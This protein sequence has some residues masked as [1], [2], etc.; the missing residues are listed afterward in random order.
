MNCDLSAGWSLRF[1]RTGG[2]AGR[3]DTLTIDHAGK[4]NASSERPP[5]NTK[6]TVD[7]ETLN[8]I[9][10]AIQTDCPFE[11]SNAPQCADCYAYTLDI[12][13]SNKEYRLELNDL[14]SNPN[15]MALVQL[16]AQTLGA[17]LAH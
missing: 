5:K 7:D 13:I 12:T 11:K 9:A 3:S 1:T 14:S 4:L 8:L 6:T 15:A 2:I 17:A 10:N 16:L